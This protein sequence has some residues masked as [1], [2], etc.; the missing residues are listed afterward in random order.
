MNEEEREEEYK[1]SWF[2]YVLAFFIG[3]DLGG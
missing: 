1:I 2:W 3:W